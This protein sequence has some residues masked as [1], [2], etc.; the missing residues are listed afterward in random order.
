VYYIKPFDPWKS[1]LCTCPSKYNLN[2]Y[3]GCSHGCIYCYASLYIKDF[4]RPRIK[5]NFFR[6]IEKDLEKIPPGSLLSLSNSSDPYLPQEKDMLFTRKF[7]GKLVGRNLRVLIITKSNLVLRDIDI[8]KKLN[9][10]CTLTLT[11]FKYY[12]K[13]EPF[14]PS[15]FERLEAVKILHNEGIKV[16]IRIDP[17]IPFLNVEEALDILYR[18]APFI[19][20]LTTSTLKMRFS[21]YRRIIKAFPQLKN[22]LYQLYFVKGE[23]KQGY[24]YLPLSLREEYLFPL[25]DACEKMGIKFAT[26]REGMS[27]FNTAPA[28]DGS[29]MINS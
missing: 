13:L 18:C 6:C 26:C 14:C 11:S 10:A 17:L 1:S 2:I 23:K 20:H 25:K 5:K 24:L 21:L 29:W 16:G 12:K 9:C 19:Q 22:K 8:L 15:S 3:T 4:F 28:C 27:F 7:L